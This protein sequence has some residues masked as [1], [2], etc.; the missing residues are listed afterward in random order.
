MRKALSR[1]R[2]AG[3]HGETVI[4]TDCDAFGQLHDLLLEILFLRLVGGGAIS[5]ENVGASFADVPT[6][7][8][9]GLRAAGRC[10]H[11]R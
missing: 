6:V 1:R 3:D 5:E 7:G 4:G 2:R 9:A 11:C 10:R 8:I